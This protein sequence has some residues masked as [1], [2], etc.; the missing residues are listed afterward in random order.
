MITEKP[1]W[2]DWE[3]NLV[4]RTEQLNQNQKPTNKQRGS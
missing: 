4:I 3:A 1:T 2:L